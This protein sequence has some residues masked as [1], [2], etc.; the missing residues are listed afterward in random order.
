MPLNVIIFGAPGSGKG[1]ASEFLVKNYGFVHCSA[2]DL[3]RDEVKRKTRLGRK[4]AAIMAEGSLI[5]D[6][7]VIDLICNRLRH[8]SVRARGVLLDGFPRTLKQAQEL[9]KRGFEFDAMIFLNVPSSVLL[10]R[11]LCRR[12]D[13]I[14]GKIY[15]LKSDPPPPEVVDRLQIRSD[16]TK[17]KHNH[18]MKI[19]EKQKK[20]LIEHYSDIVIEF[21]ADLPIMEVSRNIQK[22][23]DKVA[24]KNK[25]KMKLRQLMFVSKVRQKSLGFDYEAREESSTTIRKEKKKVFFLICK[26][27]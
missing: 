4:A 23:L 27:S 10:D 25:Y 11:C 20:A 19:F 24:E 8:P 2:G 5:P 17:E 21:D 7:L 26:S 12:L 9:S 1:T 3:L 22:A 14:T 18:R 15:N 6:E 13:P 16:D